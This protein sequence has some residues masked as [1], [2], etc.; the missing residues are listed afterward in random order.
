MHEIGQDGGLVSAILIWLLD[1]GYIDGALVSYLE[2][3]GSTWKAKPGVA[4][5]KDEVLAAAGSRYT[6]SANSLA[7]DEAMEQGLENLA[8]VG[9]GCQTSVAAGDVAPQD[10]Q[11]RQADQVQHRPA[12]LQDLRRPHLRGAVRGQVRHR[13]S[14]RSR[15]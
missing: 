15:R 7:Y 13:A 5:T 8:L 10:R 12:V 6:Y 11:G 9:M 4:T 14:R 3:D 2:G 1:E